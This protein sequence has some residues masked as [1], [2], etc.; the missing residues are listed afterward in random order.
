[1]S[2]PTIWKGRCTGIGRNGGR[3][4]FP[5]PVT[6]AHSGQFR[7]KWI[8]SASHHQ[9]RERALNSLV[10]WAPTWLQW[11]SSIICCRRCS[12]TTTRLCPLRFVSTNINTLSTI[13]N[14]GCWSVILRACV[15]SLGSSPVFRNRMISLSRS[16]FCCSSLNEPGT[17]S[18]GSESRRA[19]TSLSLFT[20]DTW[21]SF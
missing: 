8:T 1:M 9:C 5:P 19:S 3:L 4:V 17:I 7:V 2:T 16:S 6:I 20:T 15:S 14:S 10:K 11:F 12:G 21:T 13:T 18:G